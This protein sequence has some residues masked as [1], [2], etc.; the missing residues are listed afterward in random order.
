MPIPPL[1]EVQSH[2]DALS[3]TLATLFEG[4]PIL[5]ND[6][7]PQVFAHLQQRTNPVSSYAELI[8]VSLHI[9]SQWENTLKAQF[10]AGHP[11]IGEQKNLSHLSA[12]EQTAYATPPEVIIRL[13]HLN[14]C[15]EHRYPGFRYITF[16]NG[17]T[18]SAIMEEMEDVLGLERSLSA[19]QP[20]VESVGQVEVGGVPWTK[21]LERAVQD[22]G[23]IAK[24]R[25]KT[26]GT[27]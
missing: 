9:I 24:S 17:R 18:R 14:A 16:V 25:L 15:F 20:D 27:E 10:I 13:A 1:E 12:Q 8:D 4:S 2:E 21:E 3:K 19:D 7:S 23:K 26:L 5:Y 22:V 11:R 6:L